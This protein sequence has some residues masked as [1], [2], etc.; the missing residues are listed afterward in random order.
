MLLCLQ[1]LPSYHREQLQAVQQQ[2]N[3]MQ[4]A[5][6]TQATENA[7]A[8][9]AAAAAMAQAAAD[10]AANQQTSRSPRQAA[11]P[12]RSASPH[13]NRRISPQPPSRAKT[14]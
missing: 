3:F 12:I 4:E 9:V 10:A 8:Q 1:A 6:E 14:T 7:A 5:L 13:H 11:V 2:L